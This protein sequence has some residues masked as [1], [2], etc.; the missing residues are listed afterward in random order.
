MRDS[1]PGAAATRQGRCQVGVG[2]IQVGA[3]FSAYNCFVHVIAALERQQH[4]KD[5]AEWAWDGY[6]WALLLSLKNCRSGVGATLGGPGVKQL[7]C[8]IVWTQWVEL[9]AEADIPL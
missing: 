7:S 2:W 9:G 5:A 4:A 1:H 6:I 3:P 8:R